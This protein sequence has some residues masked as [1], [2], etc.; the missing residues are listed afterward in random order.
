[1]VTVA[2][3]LDK[4]PKMFVIN[5]SSPCKFYCLPVSMLYRVRMK[6]AM[7]PVFGPPC[8]QFLRDNFL[9]ITIGKRNSKRLFWAVQTPWI[10]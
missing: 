10:L 2:E 9:A 8:T 7:D 6:I 1:M 3:K 4:R 5:C